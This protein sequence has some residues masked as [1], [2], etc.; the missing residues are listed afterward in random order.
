MASTIKYKFI[1]HPETGKKINIEHNRGGLYAY[2][3]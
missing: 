3:N 1:V 2:K